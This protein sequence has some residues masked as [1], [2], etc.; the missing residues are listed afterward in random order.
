MRDTYVIG[1]DFGTDSLRSLLINTRTGEEVACDIQYYKRWSEGLYCDPEKFQYRHHPKDYIESF[2]RSIKKILKK[3]PQNLIKDIEGIGVC[4]TGSTIAPVDKFGTVLSLKESFENDPDAMFILWKDHTATVESERVNQV[5]KEWRGQDFTT[6]CGG[7]YSSEWFWAKI[8]H[9]VKNNINVRSAAYSWVELCDWIPAV[10]AEIQNPLFIKRSRCTAGHKALWHQNWNGLPPEEFFTR[11]DPLLG[12]LRKRLYEATYTSDKKAGVLSEWWAKRFGL[13]PNITISVGA[14]DAHAGS[15]ANK[16]DEN[17]I[18]MILGTSAC[19]LAVAK[20]EMIGDTVVRGICGQVDGSVIPGMIGLEAAQ[21]AF[22]DIFFW[23][24]QMLL[25]PFENIINESKSIDKNMYKKL[26]NTVDSNILNI[27]SVEA[28]KFPISQKGPLSIDWFNGRNSPFVNEKLKGA[29]TELTLGTGAVD[30]FRS[31]VESTA[32]G[33]KAII[34]R[35]K[36]EGIHTDKIIASGG[37]SK[38]SSYIMQVLC[39]VLETPISVMQTEYASA[40]GAGIYCAV[41]HGVYHSMAEA[42]KRMGSNAIKVYHPNEK[43]FNVYRTLY[44]KYK[45]LGNSLSMK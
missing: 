6:Y 14:L 44:S 31:L 35:F 24:K 13:K 20:Y 3:I 30:I 43:N 2:E 40:L 12:G 22:G 19:Y 1:L 29:I 16:I 18:S 23:F 38:K 32:F 4:A 25:W 21:S 28:S 45:N 26:K 17:T 42:Q 41:A 36:E 11:V 5:S 27:L 10:L 8:L 15:V 9:I 34:E 37:I 7:E 33:A 39:D